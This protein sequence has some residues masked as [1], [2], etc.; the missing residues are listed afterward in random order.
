MRFLLDTHVLLWALAAPEEL[1]PVAQDLLTDPENEVFVSPV[2]IWEIEIKRATGLLEAPPNL[3]ADIAEVGFTPLPMT[4]NHAHTA[5]RL[6]RHHGDPFDRL[7]IGQAIEES[8]TLITV[9][10][11]FPNYP[12]NLLPADR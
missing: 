4:F 1:G 5:A 12:V 11:A 9:D 10:G 3:L 2:S 6:P 7:L 8:L